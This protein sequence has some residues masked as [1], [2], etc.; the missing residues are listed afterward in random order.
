MPSLYKILHL[1]VI[2]RI[3][4][5]AKFGVNQISGVYKIIALSC[6]KQVICIELYTTALR[7]GIIYVKLGLCKL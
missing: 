3:I 6:V 1:I 5:Y 4:T 2:V 7:E